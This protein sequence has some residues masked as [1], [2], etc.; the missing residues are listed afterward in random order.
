MRDRV[1]PVI[2]ASLLFILPTGGI[3]A[4][5]IPHGYLE[6]HCF[7]CHDASKKK[8]RHSSTPRNDS[9]NGRWFTTASR[10]AKCRPSPVVPALLKRKIPKH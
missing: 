5:I 1:G 2:L 8:G 10:Q 7:D 4:D 3:S 9:V 6:A